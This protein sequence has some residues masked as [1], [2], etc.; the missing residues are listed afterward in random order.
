MNCNTIYALLKMICINS[1]CGWNAK[2]SILELLFLKNCEVQ[3]QRTKLM[4][5][6]DIWNG[7]GYYFDDWIPLF[8]P[9]P[10]PS[11]PCTLEWEGCRGFVCCNAGAEQRGLKLLWFLCCYQCTAIWKPLREPVNS[12]LLL[13]ILNTVKKAQGFGTGLHFSLV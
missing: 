12:I 13:Y 6:S 4:F 10:L 3:H 2:W 9:L 11:G 8:A 7:Q 1:V 5:P